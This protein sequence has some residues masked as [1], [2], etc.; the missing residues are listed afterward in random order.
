MDRVDI[1]QY[2]PNPC[3]EAAYVILRSCLN[4]LIRCDLI[5]N[6]PRVVE[7]REATDTD[8]NVVMPQELP[9]LAEVHVHLWN[10]PHAPGMQLWLL[11]KKC[12]VSCI[13]IVNALLY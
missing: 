13:D 5:V 1:K 10:Q 12:Q 4:E 7:D 3:A 8:W 11:A 2:I 6:A 9:K